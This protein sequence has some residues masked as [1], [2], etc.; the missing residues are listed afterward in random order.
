[1]TTTTREVILRIKTQMD[2]AMGRTGRAA[3][4]KSMASDMARLTQT[5]K[6]QAPVFQAATKAADA[7]TASLN[8][9]ATA[10]ARVRGAQAPAQP[11]ASP[12]RWRWWRF[13][14]RLPGK[15]DP[16]WRGLGHRA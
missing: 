12:P 16:R 5:V 10:M 6:N 3:D 4:T 1:M 2:S 11:M 13:G 7:Y 15:H 9:L 14:T 8:K